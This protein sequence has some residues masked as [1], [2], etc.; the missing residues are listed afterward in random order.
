MAITDHYYTF[1]AP[2]IL[3]DVR[4]EVTEAR[5]MIPNAPEVFFSCEAEVMTPGTT[6]GTQELADR[7]DFVM[8]A[9]THFQN[10][11]ITDLPPGDDE[12][13]ATHYLKM[14]EYSV[15]LPWVD[16]IAH[17]F[18][19]VPNVC[20]PTVLDHLKDSSLLAAIELAKENGVAMEISRRALWPHQVAFSSRFYG[21]CKRVG[22]HFTIGSDAHELKDIGNVQVVR[23]LLDEIGVS[24]TD[25]WL[26]DTKH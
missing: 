22:L 13:H 1:T 16:T 23:P 5:R 20:S 4:A 6:A 21:L 9:A 8:A 19:V 25:I 2:G 3:D 11:G 10:K 18:L 15:G 14:F 7:L 26:P 24:E 12:S 17:P